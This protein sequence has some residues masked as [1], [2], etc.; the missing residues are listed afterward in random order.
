MWNAEPNARRKGSWLS[1][2]YVSHVPLARVMGGKEE[3]RG[4]FGTDGER[5]GAGAKSRGISVSL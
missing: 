4:R 3:V 1:T 5:G 2:A